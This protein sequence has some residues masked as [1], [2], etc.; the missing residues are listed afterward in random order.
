[1]AWTAPR[2]WVTGEQVTAALLNTHVRDNL[3]AL[4]IHTHTGAAGDGDDVLT[5]LDTLTFDDQV[6]S[7]STAGRLQRN[8]VNLQWYTGSAVETLA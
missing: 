7:P 8:G 2:R 1:M 4:S 6:G 5:G 3:L